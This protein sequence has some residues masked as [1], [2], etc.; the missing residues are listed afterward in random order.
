MERACRRADGQCDAPG[1]LGKIGLAERDPAPLGRCPAEQVEEARPFGHLHQ[2]GQAPTQADQ[3]AR[4]AKDVG[5]TV[6]IGPVEPRR[7]VV[8]AVVVV[9]AALRPADLVAHQQHR[10]AERQHLDGEEVPDLAAPE[11]LDL[12]VGGR[13]LDT[14]VPAQVLV[15]AIPVSL[16][17]RLVM[18]PVVRG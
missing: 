10:H 12:G 8:V 1:R 7:R 18:L 16:A 5:V 14:A 9:V 13:S 15:V 3:A 2:I 6:G 17:V 4:E 11:P